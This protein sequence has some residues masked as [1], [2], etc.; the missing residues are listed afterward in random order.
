MGAASLQARDIIYGKTPRDMN[1][2]T[3]WQAAFLQGGGL[4]IFGDFLL[5]DQSRF[6]NSVVETLAGPVAGFGADVVKVFKGNFDR[7][8]QEGTETKFF[9]DLY[10]M[11]ERNIPMAK[12]W[13]TR[14]FLE[15][16]MLDHVESAIDPKY[17][18]R[19]R[20]IESKLKRE[21]GQEFW[22]K[23]SK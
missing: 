17:K 13:Y 7:S 18:T 12:L 21:K 19:M 9:A 6:G 14:L 3:F 10:Q 8:L 20:R 4:G 1:S 16:F 15:R 22:W 23:P 5:S 11:A 2:P